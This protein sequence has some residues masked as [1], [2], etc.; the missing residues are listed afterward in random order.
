MIL[1]IFDDFGD[2]AHAT[3]DGVGDD[4]DGLGCDD[5]I[6]DRDGWSEMRL[7]IRRENDTAADNSGK[8]SQ[9]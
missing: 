5:G 8:I 6:K 3:N 9:I 2:V 1:V 7:F 4:E